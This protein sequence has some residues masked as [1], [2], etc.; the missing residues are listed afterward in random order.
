MTN[1]P[2]VI[3]VTGGSGSGKSSVSK[4][5]LDIFAD[6]PVMLLQQDYYY[7][8]QTHLPFEERL[9]TNYDH[10]LAF[11]NELFAEHIAAL[12]RGEAIERPIY[13]YVAHTRSAESVHQESKDVI[14]IEGLLILEDERL[15]DLMD[16]KVYVD[17][18]D[19]IR[20]ARRILRDIKERGRSVDSVIKQYVEVV[21][22]MHHQFI[23]PTKRYADII[24]PE[25][26][27]NNV[28]IDLIATKIQAILDKK[29]S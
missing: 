14:I 22:P 1:R 29:Q 8:D 13:D 25:G 9:L 2:I 27:Y 17:T 18:D 7:K 3:G 23:E 15:R 12:L 6:L 11:D 16:I 19:D 26:G 20:L 24:V 21:K 4:R 10:P 28:A 5:I